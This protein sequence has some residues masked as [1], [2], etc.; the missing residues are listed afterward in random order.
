M[1]PT[2]VYS[3]SCRHLC[4]CPSLSK[5]RLTA[6]NCRMNHPD[7]S[8]SFSSASAF[9]FMSSPIRYSRR[10]RPG[11]FASMAEDATLP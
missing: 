9:L 11:T 1:A 10:R 5:S 6:F 4:T 2:A 8:H 3:R 7:A